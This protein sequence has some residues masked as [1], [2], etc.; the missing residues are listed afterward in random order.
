MLRVILLNLILFALPFVVYGA[1]LRLQGKATT[2]DDFWTKAP[3]VGLFVASVVLVLTVMVLFASFT[4][5]D[6]R[7][8][9][10]PP[11]FKDGK[12]EP[13]KVE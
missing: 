3:I 12:I 10:T 13:G 1:V 6:P 7:G 2:L 11:V 9:Y 4:G 8:H 5:D